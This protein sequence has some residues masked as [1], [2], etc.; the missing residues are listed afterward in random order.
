MDFGPLL[1]KSRKMAGLTQEQMAE[2]LNMSRPC[3]SK[4]ERGQIELKAVDLIRWFRVTNMQEVAAAAI[5]GVDPAV[6]ATIMSQITQLI[7]VILVWKF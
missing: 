3:I 5:C 4:L 7:G 2:K 6:L 1:R